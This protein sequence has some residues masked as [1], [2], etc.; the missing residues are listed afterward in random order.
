[1]KGIILAGGTGTRLFPLTSVVSK[2][3][4]PV[5]DKP[6]IYYPLSVLMLA[7]VRDILIIS[8]PAD[9]PLF[10]RL[11]GDGSHLGV[12][13]SY[14]SQAEPRGL[15]DAF[16]IGADHIGDDKVALVLGD[17]IFHGQAFSD[18]LLRSARFSEGCVL[19]G[20]TVHDPE[21]YGVAEVDADGRL[22]SLEEKP[23]LP[24]SNRAVTGLYFYD[25][26]VV[27]IARR[28][29]PS[30]RGELEI[31]D[32]NRVYLERG[33]ARLVQ[34]GRGFAWLDT[35]THRSLMEA[36]KYIEILE[37]RQGVRIACLEEVALRMGYIDAEAC[38]RL[39]ERLGASEY[40]R[41]IMG[42][43]NIMRASELMV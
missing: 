34:L 9:L 29:R 8:T 28:L 5:Y 26:D 30:P 39:G 18:L 37:N 36:G 6:M 32:V 33:T 3:L 22:I 15:A 27:S 7:G 20:Y 31:T 42:V 13:L 11:L 41:Y 21:R 19:F 35:G 43:A 2:Q 16:L 40:G 14:A 24:R 25:N 1:M 4:L 23:A 17:N 10:R 12:R 38:H